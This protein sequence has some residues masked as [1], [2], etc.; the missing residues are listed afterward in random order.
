MKLHIYGLCLFPFD[1]EFCLFTVEEYKVK[2][3]KKYAS[4]EPYY[5]AVAGDLA[6]VYTEIDHLVE[7][8]LSDWKEQFADF[9]DTLR[10]PPMI[11]AIPSG[12]HRGSAAFGIVLKRDEDGD[13]CVYS[14][15]P[16]PHLEGV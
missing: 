10:C 1:W 8:A 15:V 11:F 5:N 6:E 14:S 13:T 2:L 16:L 4:N 9:D 3:A 7:A 12:D